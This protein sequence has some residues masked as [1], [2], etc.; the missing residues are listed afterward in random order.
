MYS[1][2]SSLEVQMRV[3]VGVQA[4][5]G[6]EAAPGREVNPNGEICS[7]EVQTLQSC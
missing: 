2:G 7:E 1:R 5:G 6:A 4:G 3:F